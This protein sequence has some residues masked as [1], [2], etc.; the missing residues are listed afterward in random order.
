[1][2]IFI[3]IV[4]CFGGQ[5]RKCKETVGAEDYCWKTCQTS[6][7]KKDIKPCDIAVFQKYDICDCPDKQAWSVIELKCID[8]CSEKCASE[9]DPTANYTTV[10]AAEPGCPAKPVDNIISN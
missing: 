1:M 8:F 6:S 4:P 9:Y 3:F 2:F 5:V 10:P 7:Y